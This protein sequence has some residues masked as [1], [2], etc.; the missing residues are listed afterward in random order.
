MEYKLTLSKLQMGLPFDPE[1]PLLG[2]YI[3]QIYIQ[4]YGE[5]QMHRVI[6]YSIV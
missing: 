4:S 2:L 1:V 3:S 5:C 6:H